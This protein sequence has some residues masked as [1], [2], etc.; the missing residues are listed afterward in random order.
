V[1]PATEVNG[2]DRYVQRGRPLPTVLTSSTNIAHDQENH[3]N[4]TNDSFEFRI[5]RKGTRVAT[6]EIADFFAI[7]SY[8]DMNNLYND[9]FHQKSEKHVKA[10]I[11]QLPTD[12]P[13]EISKGLEELGH[14]VISV[15]QM[16]TT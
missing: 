12:T 3:K 13:T 9:T 2:P 6:K 7:W 15:K 16:S 8:F 1:K 14:E 11:R 10:V 5:T 4:A